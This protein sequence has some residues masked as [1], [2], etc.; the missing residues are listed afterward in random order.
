MTDN[1]IEKYFLSLYKKLLNVRYDLKI[2]HKEFEALN[3]VNALINRQKAELERLEKENEILSKNAD[4]AFQDG[5]NEAQDLYAEQV[6]A[7]IRAESRKEFAERLKEKPIPCK[8][9]L[10][11]LSTR[12]EIEDYFNEIMLEV[13]KAINNLLEEMESESNG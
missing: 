1:D 7:E 9:P 13:N 6:K 11:G 10:L 2:T 12:S 3:S 5:L 8:L 4:T